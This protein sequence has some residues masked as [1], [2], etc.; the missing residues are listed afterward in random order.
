MT[1]VEYGFISSDLLAELMAEYGG[2]E[3]DEWCDSEED[4]AQADD[5]LPP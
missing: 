2:E 1:R 5:W 4:V 3:N